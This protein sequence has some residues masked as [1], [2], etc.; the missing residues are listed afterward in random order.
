MK[1][2]VVGGGPAGLATLRFL[3]HAH[4][5]FPIPP[6]EG[7][8]FEG[9]KDIGGTFSYRVYEDAELVSSKY[10]TA[11]SDFRLPEDAPDFVTPAIY[12]RYLK[13]YATAFELWPMIEL[14]TQVDQ[15]RRGPNGVGHIVSLHCKDTGKLTHWACDA[16]AV[17]T[18]INVNPVIPEIKGVER[19]PSVLHSSQLKT[20]AQFGED[21]NV[22]IMGAGETGM[23]LA[24]L[25]ITSKA[26]SVT[27]CHRDGFFC[28][29]KASSRLT[30]VFKNQH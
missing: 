20:R 5:Y 28:A 9:E 26:K 3:A 25:A 24:Y 29:P 23:D 22:Y 27:L 21:T 10:L 11:F 7:R 13:A 8:L 15:I 12:V 19:V 18:G 4:D 2:A 1:V 16:V 17:C 30:V 6:I 14:H